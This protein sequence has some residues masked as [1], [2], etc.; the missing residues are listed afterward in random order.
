MVQAV[1]PPPAELPRVIQAL[2]AVS[3]STAK[4]P[5]NRPGAEPAGADHEPAAIA[6]EPA[7]VDHKPAAVAAEPAAVD[8]KPAVVAAEPAAVEHKPAA[9]EPRPAE[10]TPAVVVAALPEGT[11]SAPVEPAAAD[12]QATVDAKPEALV[13]TFPTNSSY[14]PPDTSTH[15]AALLQQA[16]NDQR[17]EVILQASVSGSEKVVGA[18][19][20][21][22]AA[23]YNHWL[24]ERRVERVRDWL[25]QNVKGKA[26][27]IKPE[28]LTNDESRQVVVRLVPTG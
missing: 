3:P 2:P 19:S 28:Y 1:E 25:G 4:A 12:R 7:A 18:E 16:A 5:A 13:I 15:L 8:H 26:L 24:A 10:S 9:A 27:V 22:E 14:F 17:V 11:A 21:E 23:Q 20:S 6:A